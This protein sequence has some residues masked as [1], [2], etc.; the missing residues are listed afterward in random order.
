MSAAVIDN[1]GRVRRL[2]ARAGEDIVVTSRDVTD[3]ER[4]ARMVQDLK[5]D[6]AALKRAWRPARVYFRDVALPASGTVRL[7]HGLGGK[8]Y[9]WV[10]DWDSTGAAAESPRLDR[11]A[12]Q[13]DKNHI[14][15]QSQRV[16]T[17]TI[18]VEEAG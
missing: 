3:M 11:V 14:V 8:V 12:T 5:R 2:D 1:D 4:L 15:L 7:E 6:V 10:V 17:A 18:C 16:G 13:D 9:W